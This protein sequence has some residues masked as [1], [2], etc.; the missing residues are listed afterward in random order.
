YVTGYT[1][2]KKFQLMNALQEE[3]HES[4]C[5]TFSSQRYCFDAFITKFSPSGELL[6]STY[7]GA[8]FDEYLY[9]IRVDDKGTIYLVGTTEADDFPTTEN[10]YEPSNLLSDDAF[11]VKIG[12]PTGTNTP[13]PPP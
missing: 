3:L 2:G 12:T 13:P 7:L 5:Y 8:T 4:F 11:L 10:A 1:S 9:G 6:M